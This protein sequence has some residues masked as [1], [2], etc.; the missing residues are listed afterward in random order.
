MKP[1]RHAELIVEILSLDELKYFLWTIE[2]TSKVTSIQC[3]VS[4]I[5]RNTKNW[6]NVTRVLVY[7]LSHWCIVHGKGEGSWGW[8][9]H[10]YNGAS[11]DHVGACLATVAVLTYMNPEKRH[12]CRGLPPAVTCL[13]WRQSW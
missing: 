10:S 6:T 5:T 7:Y 9:T 3:N 4:S 8:T 13:Y 2:H 1:V 11:I 12:F